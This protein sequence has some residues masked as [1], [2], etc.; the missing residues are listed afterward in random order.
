MKVFTV[1]LLDEK[2][3]AGYYIDIGAYDF[4]CALYFVR[5]FDDH[6]GKEYCEPDYLN[7]ISFLLSEQ[8]TI[9]EDEARKQFEKGWLVPALKKDL[10]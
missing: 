5:H 2:G 10:E 7:Y 1:T 8:K 4:D 3:R 6:Y 9:S